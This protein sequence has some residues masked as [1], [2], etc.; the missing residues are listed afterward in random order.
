M[1]AGWPTSALRVAVGAIAPRS[2]PAQRCGRARCA[3]VFGCSWQLRLAAVAGAPRRA[4]TLSGAL[5]LGGSH[6][7]RVLPI[8]GCPRQSH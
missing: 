1:R 3:P 8:L 2:G 6:G 4:I 5:P 7:F